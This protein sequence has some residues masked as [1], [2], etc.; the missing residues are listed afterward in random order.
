M[1][2]SAV[3]AEDRR[4]GLALLL[5]TALIWGANWPAAK[6]VVS[7]MPPLVAR[8]GAGIGGAAL[9]FLA[10]G[11]SGE[12]LRLP[13]SQVPRLLLL[14]FLNVTSWIGLSTM[15]LLWLPASETAIFAYTMPIWSVAFAWPLL[16]EHP[17]TA[18]LGG[19]ALGFGGVAVLIGGR[20]IAASLAQWPGILCVLCAAALW[21]LGTVLAKRLPLRMPSAVG[22][23]WQILLGTIPLTVAGLI[24]ERVDGSRVTA[25]GWAA[26]GYNGVFSFG[27]AYVTWFAALRRL[28]ASTAA[29]GTLLI[30]VLGVFSA[31]LLLGE[32]LGV[33]QLAALALTLSGIALA[34]RG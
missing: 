22:T 9:A 4:S 28:P 24:F 2:A 26:L 25:L 29:V 23:A 5:V 32:P 3:A 20:S 14:A 21:A 10:A 11:I 16:G 34:T 31:A 13:A 19:L 30:P 15:A 33:R 7:E 1:S 12:R 27:L 8:G 6:L 18:R 17:G